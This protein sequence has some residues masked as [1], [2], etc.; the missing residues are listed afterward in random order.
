MLWEVVDTL[1]RHI[2]KNNPLF[3][4]WYCGFAERLLLHASLI[5]I[6]MPTNSKY[7]LSSNF[8][9]KLII[10]SITYFRK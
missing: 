4:S 8:K 1:F 9:Y 6:I 7:G 10:L 3:Y 2:D 5:Q